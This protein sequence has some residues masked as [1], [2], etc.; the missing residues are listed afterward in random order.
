M[1]L[2]ID[3]E[4]DKD[5]INFLFLYQNNNGEQFFAHPEQVC[6]SSQILFFPIQNNFIEH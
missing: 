3:E 6:F 1:Y 2:F 4:R 5:N